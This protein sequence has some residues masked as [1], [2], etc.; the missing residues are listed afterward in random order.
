MHLT[1]SGKHWHFFKLGTRW[2]YTNPDLKYLQNNREKKHIWKWRKTQLQWEKLHLRIWHKNHVTTVIALLDWWNTEIFVSS[3]TRL[4]NGIS[5]PLVH[6]TC[7]NIYK[8]LS[9][10]LGGRIQPPQTK[11]EIKSLKILNCPP[12]KTGRTAEKRGWLKHLFLL[13]DDTCVNN[14]IFYC[15]WE[16]YGQIPLSVFPISSPVHRN[17]SHKIRVETRKMKKLKNGAQIWL[18]FSLF[19]EFV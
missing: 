16:C 18:L 6:L 15:I 17:N 10:G 14:E 5:P 4:N 12:W 19:M 11:I 13:N 7:Y 3:N 9:P 8:R 2:F 1:F